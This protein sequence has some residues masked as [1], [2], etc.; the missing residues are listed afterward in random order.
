MNQKIVSFFFALR[1]FGSA[2]FCHL[3]MSK[4]YFI[5][6]HNKNMVHTYPI[7][8]LQRN[9]MKNLYLLY[10]TQLTLIDLYHARC[11]AYQITDV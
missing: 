11:H 8:E 9:T 3:R 4:I 7:H 10:K 6:E 5:Q 2:L 1:S